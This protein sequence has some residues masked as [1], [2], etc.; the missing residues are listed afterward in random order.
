MA[1]QHKISEY[2]ENMEFKKTLGGGLQ[3][4]EVYET[5]R[6]L[7]SMYNDVLAEAY[8][9]TAELRAALERRDSAPPPPAPPAP[10]TPPPTTWEGAPVSYAPPASAYAYEPPMPA[11]SFEMTPPPA[12]EPPAVPPVVYET[13]AAEPRV[14]ED[15]PEDEEPTEDEKPAL[16]AA[17]L[18]RM[19]RRRLLELLLE[20]SRENVQQRKDMAELKAKNR[21]LQK[22]LEDKR[23]KIEKAGTLAEASLLLNGVVE[24]TQAAAAQYL[25]NLRDLELRETVRCE[26]KEA[27]T[28]RQAR[29]I[30][31][32]ARNECDELVRR[33]Q[34]QCSAMETQTRTACASMTDRAR[35]E[36]D[37]HW[38]Q[39]SDKLEAFY[40]A[41]EG[42][43]E[44]LRNTG[45]I[46]GG[47]HG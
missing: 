18:R 5:I 21:K 42:L 25:E 39:L 44:L 16:T 32:N 37:E 11:F 2:I 14:D 20:C 36:I 13:P 19:N 29:R 9:E 45:Q 10:P 22:Q 26:E 6:E 27:Q 3:P 17:D 30:L 12:Q 38:D 28:H 34:E 31:E 41:H 46:P 8:Q 33:T 40:T 35:A 7:T 4:D 15:P 24:A 23:I 47:G 43:K 1:D